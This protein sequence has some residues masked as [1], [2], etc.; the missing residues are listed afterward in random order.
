M[1]IIFSIYHIIRIYTSG[2]KLVGLW[3]V[4]KLA[5]F[6]ELLSNLKRVVYLING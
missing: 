1:I 3:Q 5:F 4:T 6:K 2:E